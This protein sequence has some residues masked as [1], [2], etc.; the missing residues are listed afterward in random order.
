M[1]K[2]YDTM[3]RDLREFVPIE[4]DKVK[5]Y[6]CGP[7]VYNYI[8]VGNARSTVAFDTIRRYFEY[9][10]YEVAY[11]SNFTDVDDKI[12]NRAKEEGITPQEVADKYIAAFRE[13]VTTLGVQP[14]TQHPRVVDYMMDII[15]FVQVLV[16]KGFAYESEG[17]V[18]FRV[19]KS[20]NYAKLANKSLADLELG[21]SGRT[22]EE[23]TRKEN[24]VDFALWK[25][26]KPGEIFWDS[27]WGPGRPGWHITVSYTH[28]T[29]PTNREV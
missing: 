20:S 29:L 21:A 1:I 9:R 18:Y 15:D 2:I 8:H 22:D 16:D 17:D 23:T 12:I 10:G 25:A 24:P 14:A 5:M 7:T 3:F 19:E 13:D 26:A 11:I 28:L 27:P 6:V 4:D